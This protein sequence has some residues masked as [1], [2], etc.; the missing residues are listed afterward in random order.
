MQ[1]MILDWIVGL[2]TTIKLTLSFLSSWYFYFKFLRILIFVFE[3]LEIKS[4][5]SFIL[6]KPFITIFASLEGTLCSSGDTSCQWLF[7]HGWRPQEPCVRPP[8]PHARIL[9]GSVW[10]R[11]PQLLPADICSSHVMSRRW[12]SQ[13]SSSSFGSCGTGVIENC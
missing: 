12:N 5:Y 8:F 9:T 13:Y 2:K 1:F 11:Q 10:Y 3:A 4:I 6:C 7:H